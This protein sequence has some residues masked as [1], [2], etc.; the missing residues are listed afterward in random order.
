MSDRIA[1]FRAGRL[2]QF[3]TPLGVYR[4]PANRFVASFVGSP[5]MAFLPATVGE[6][7]IELLGVRLPAPPDLPAGL[8]GRAV[9]LGVRSEDVV[10]GGDGPLRAT[11]ELVEHLGGAAII[12]L[13]RQGRRLLAGAGPTASYRA[14]Q[15]V[16]IGIDPRQLYLFDPMTEAAIRT[17]GAAT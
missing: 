7:T 3:D 4:S 16:A 10:I 12:H 13:A 11:V 1:V 8:A 17:P 5:P 2:Q 6:G 14:G 9:E 15:E